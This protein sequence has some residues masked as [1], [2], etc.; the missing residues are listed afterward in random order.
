MTWTATLAAIGGF[1][2][3]AAPTPAVAY[4]GFAALGLG[5]A[6]L[7]PLGFALGGQYLSE[8]QRPLGIARMTLIG[9]MG[10]FFGPPILGVLAEAFGL[11]VAFAVIGGML[12]VFP[13]LLRA[14]SAPPVSPD[15]PAPPPSHTA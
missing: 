7:A 1:I 8:A 2:A 5:I 4:I 11:R 12:V 15:S 3:A 9:Y 10:F 13:I 14:L 6:T